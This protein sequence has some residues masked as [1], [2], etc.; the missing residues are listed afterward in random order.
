MGL[1]PEPVAI[2]LVTV[3]PYSM[4]SCGPVLSSLNIGLNS[5]AS[6][7]WP[8]ANR[9]VLVPFSV[10]TTIT[11][12][13]LFL[14]MGTAVSGNV[15]VG[16]YDSTGRKI[17]SSG[18]T[19]QT[20]ANTQQEFDIT[21]TVLPPGD[22]YLA[23]VLDNTTG[24]TWRVA[25]NTGQCRLAGVLNANTAFPLPDTVTFVQA[26]SGYVPYIGLTTRDLL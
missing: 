23:C 1:W 4:E 17:V 16:I 15:D 8:S 19:V 5:A 6:G 3:H 9:A 26:A 24:T 22:Y 12:K 10:N 13:K 14:L 25:P 21:D 11:V 7:A 20:G 18:S 2:P